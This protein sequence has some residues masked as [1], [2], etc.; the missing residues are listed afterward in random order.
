MKNYRPHTYGY[1]GK[2]EQQKTGSAPSR[3]MGQKPNFLISGRTNQL[4]GIVGDL[5]LRGRI[6]YSYIILILRTLLIDVL[7]STSMQVAI[8]TT[9]LR[10]IIN[11]SS[12]SPIRNFDG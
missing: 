2:I 12:Y 5:K 3:N 4:G 9:G 10:N 7:L 6:K 8:L 11:Q 1:E